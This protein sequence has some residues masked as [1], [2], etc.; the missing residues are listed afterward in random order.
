MHRRICMAVN[1]LNRNRN[2]FEEF[3]LTFKQAYL[4]NG[5]NLNDF[6]FFDVTTDMTV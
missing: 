6:G 5:E 3:R 4:A 2:R 1:E